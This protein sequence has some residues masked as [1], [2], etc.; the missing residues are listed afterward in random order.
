MT[1]QI[2]LVVLLAIPLAGAVATWLVRPVAVLH[3]ITAVT[4]SAV[5]V[6]SIVLLGMLLNGSP[7]HAFENLLLV[8]PL[9]GVVLLIVGSVGFTSAI[10]SIGYLH[11]ELKAG[12][13]RPRE[14]HRYYA[15]LHV[16]VFTMLLSAVS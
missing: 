3:G 2:L 16:F 11:H 8:D 10:Y 13:V 12:A 15:L 9:G 14:L 6:V 1:G 7:P 4:H 5:L